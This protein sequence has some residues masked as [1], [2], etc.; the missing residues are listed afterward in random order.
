MHRS[1]WTPVAAALLFAALAVAPAPAAEIEELFDQSYELSSGG[2]VS[3]DN[4][5]GSVVVTGWEGSRVRVEAV[6]KVRSG[7]RGRARE[8]LDRLEIRV[9]HRPDRLE[10]DTRQPSGSDGFLA[11]LFG[12]DVQAQVDY[13]VSVPR[14]TRVA[15]DTVNGKVEVRRV[16][17]PVEVGTTN[18]GVMVTDA[19]GPVDA[20][21][22][23]GAIRVELTDIE[24]DRPMR[25]STTNGGIR[26]TLPRT[27]RVTVDASTT[28]GGI[29][30]DGLPADV[31]SRGRRHLRAELGGGG[32][33]IRLTTTNGGI[34]IA[35][36]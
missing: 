18:G 13:A 22:T 5:N 21:T 19:R 27:A 11:W 8:A 30:L 2:L 3:V 35:G 36:R 31:R 32:P 4:V 16:E 14:G 20:S 1:R 17:G 33:Q 6:K 15:V 9:E 12:N 28:N 23:N 29:D 7:S 25:L 34:K 10:V 26:L 24:E